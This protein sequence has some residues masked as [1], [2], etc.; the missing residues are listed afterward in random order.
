MLKIRVIP[1][2]FLMNGLIVRSERFVDF[3]VIGN[4]V[5]ELERYSEWMAD[6]LVY[7]DIT[8]EGRS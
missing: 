5:S 7:A 3:K 4:P 1:V 2:L 6:E 8:R